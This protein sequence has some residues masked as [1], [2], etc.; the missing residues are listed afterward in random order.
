[1]TMARFVILIVVVIVDDGQPGPATVGLTA[2]A[3]AAH[4]RAPPPR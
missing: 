2:T 4:V 3:G 1:M